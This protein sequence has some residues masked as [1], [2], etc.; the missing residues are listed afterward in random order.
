M[1]FSVLLSV[2]HK[3]SPANFKLALESVWEHQ[4]LKPSEIILVKDGP[5]TADLENV[6]SGF[7]DDM[8]LRIIELKENVGLG[9]ALNIGLDNC[10]FELVARMDTDD[11]CESDRFK[12][13]VNFM[14]QHG[15]VDVL[16]SWIK[17]FDSDSGEIYAARALPE[18]HK[19][20]LV[21]SKKR[22]PIS[23]PSVMFRKSKVIEAGGYQHF[24]LYED[25]FLWVRMLQ[26]GC[27]F[28][29]L[30]M[31]LLKFRSGKNMIKRRRGYTYLISE[32]NFQRFLLKSKFIS[33]VQYIK[34]CLIRIV[35][36]LL[37][38]NLILFL[39][40]CFLRKKI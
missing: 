10:S 31:F 32:L 21:F 8:P 4:E 27:I 24:Y 25:Y 15:Q 5:L 11:I 34:N 26:N 16:G 19:D 13:Q 6:I 14:S 30:P 39:Y 22:N 29:N 20:L 3:E 33:L 40:S 28:H 36:R 38:G 35:V 18:R 37:P 12:E 1:N 2:Y 9:K 23:H 17:E 7:D